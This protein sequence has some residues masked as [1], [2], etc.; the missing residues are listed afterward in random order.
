[1]KPPRNALLRAIS[2]KM[3]DKRI[4]THLQS[5][6]YSDCGDNGGKTPTLCRVGFAYRELSTSQ[7]FT[8]ALTLRRQRCDLEIF[9]GEWLC[10]IPSLTVR[11]RNPSKNRRIA[12][13]LAGHRTRRRI[14]LWE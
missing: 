9:S 7:P 4:A 8:R 11:T 13:V 2:E 12:G 6:T 3:V 10:A 1:M 14:P 5:I